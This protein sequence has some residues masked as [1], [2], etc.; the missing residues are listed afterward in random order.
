[1]TEDL[2]MLQPRKHHYSIYTIDLMP[3]SCSADVFNGF[4][5]QTKVL[6]LSVE[7]FI[8]GTTKLILAVECLFDWYVV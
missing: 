6:S 3:H 2:Y 5:A 8:S 4:R 7:E 1:M